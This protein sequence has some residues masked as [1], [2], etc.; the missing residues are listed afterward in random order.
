LTAL[1]RDKVRQQLDALWPRETVSLGRFRQ[2]MMSA[3]RY[4]LCAEWPGPEQIEATTE[5]TAQAGSFSKISVCHRGLL[6]TVELL[7]FAPA[8]ESRYAALLVASTDQEVESIRQELRPGRRAAFVLRL[9]AHDREAASGGTEQQRQQFGPTYYRTALAWQVQDV[10]TSLAYVKDRAGYSEVQL[11]GIG[12]A[13]IPTL[14][15]RALAPTG[16]VGRT[17]ADLAGLDDEDE[18]T[19]TGSRAQAGILR[20]GGL[21]TAA[22]LAAP[23]ELVL[24]NTGAHF[25]GAVVRTAYRAAGRFSALEVSEDTWNVARILAYLDNEG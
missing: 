23:N 6:A 9:R 3:L 5:T 15:A 22:I 18:G 16:A 10:L 21:R 13:G 7:A 14:L 8:G 20:F 2:T 11:A 1:L 12:E 24:H 25:D 19:W 4:T 17:I